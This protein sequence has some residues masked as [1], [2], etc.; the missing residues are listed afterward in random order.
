[1]SA[2]ERRA[3]LVLGGTAEAVSLA[4]RLVADWGG[5]FEIVTSLAGRT[6]TPGA[7]PG[8][9]RVGG[10]G[11]VVPMAAYLKT[12][13]VCAVLDATHPFAAQISENARVASTMAEV[14]RIVL[15][16]PPWERE[17]DDN[18]HMQPDLA[19]AAAAL[20]KLGRRA[21]LTVGRTDLSAFA[22]CEDIWFLVRLI[23]MPDASLPL[24][25]YEVISGRGPFSAAAEQRLLEKHKIDA[26]VCKASG[27]EAT[28]AKLV[29]ARKHGIPVLMVER[30][31]VPSG[32][33]VDNIDAVVA[34]LGEQVT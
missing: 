25:A 8:A 32:P 10:F 6:Q 3:V 2:P 13:H 34:W 30:P 23:D 26:L 11:G 12:N 16:R 28:R 1:M 19:A 4:D 7:V 21:F 14:P 24:S 5:R 9:V 29:A 31:S 33:A 27:G 17:P 22:S 20:P 15:V 18:W